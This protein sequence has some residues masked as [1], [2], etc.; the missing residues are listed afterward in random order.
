MKRNPFTKTSIHCFLLIV[1]FFVIGVSQTSAQ[2]KNVTGNVKDDT[3]E[4]LPGA[5]IL[6]VGTTLGTMTDFDGNFEVRV[7]EKGKAISIS[8]LGYITQEIPYTGQD[9]INVMLKSDRSQLEEVVVVGYGTQKAKDVT[10]AISKIKAKDIEKTT[11][12]TVEQALTG[13]VAGVNTISSDGSLGGGMRIRIRGGTSVN[14]N[15]E[16]LYVIDGLPVEVDYTLNQVPG[17]IDQPTASPLANLDPGSIVSIEVLKDA[18]AAAIYGSRGANGVVMITTK[19]GKAGKTQIVYDTN[20]SLSIVPKNRYVKMMNTTQYGEFLVNQDRYWLGVYRP[21][22]QFPAGSGVTAEER[23]EAYK[24]E[25]NTNWQD[26][27]YQMGIITNH[28]ISA[29]GGSEGNLFSVRGAYL[30]NEGTVKNSF[31]KRYNFTMNTQ[32][33]L[34]DKLKIKTS[35]APSY[36][37]KQGPTSGGSFSQRNMGSII[38]AM[39]RQPNRVV[40][41]VEI[42]DNEDVGV[43]VDPI[44]E[45]EKTKQLTTIFSFTGNTNLIYEIFKGFTA[46]FKI[47]T[48]YSSGLVKNYF[49]KE[50]GRGW[51]NGGLG[52]RYHYTNSNVNNQNMLNYTTSFDGGK[53]RITALAGFTQTYLSIDTERIESKDFAV[54]TLGFDGLQNGQNPSRPFTEKKEKV[55]KSFLARVNYNMF[56]KYNF[57]VSM[58]ADGSSVFVNNKW[59][60]FPAAAFAWNMNGEPFIKNVKDISNMRLRLSYGQTGNAG[61]PFYNSYSLM[62]DT[63]PVFGESSSAVAGLSTTNVGDPNLRWEFTDQFDLGYEL[64]LFHNRINIVAD[65]YYK[66]TQDLLLRQPIALSTGFESNLTNIG[67]VENRGLELSLKTVNFDGDFK[68]NTEFNFALN[69]NKVLSLGANTRVTFKDQFSQQFTGLLQTGESLGNWIGYETDGIFR[70]EDFEGDKVT[71]KPELRGL[72][73]NYASDENPLVGDIKYIDRN[74][75]GTIDNLDRTIIARTQPKHY[76]SV[77]NSFSYKGFDLGV[78]FTYKYG[79]DVIN[80]NK[81]RISNTVNSNWN[82]MVSSVDAWTPVNND[83]SQPRPD[84]KQDPNFNDRSI[85]DGSFIRLQSINIGYNLPKNICGTLGLSSLKLYSNVDNIHIWTKYTGYDPEVSVAT[86]QK[87]VTSA[88]LDYG[89]YP[90]TLNLSLGI[91]VG[92]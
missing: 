74:Q 23:L 62:S 36:V 66:R 14:A 71:L 16:P 77:Y 6:V 32:N 78:F 61:V 79:V 33:K 1:F 54:E 42:D 81:H 11:N 22:A 10:G 51:Q 65:I 35:L 27:F 48:N 21:Y 31:F 67:N 15:N 90:R 64:G 20:T 49:S 56:N 30:N 70:Y 38:K 80:G 9:V 45:A 13:R 29:S 40:G 46:N 19:T 55:L 2:S 5:S 92:F 72:Y 58:R 63:F 26:E 43:W 7:T 18:S 87:A 73:G 39:S 47:G 34:T 82:K 86:G 24:L 17:A 68:W 57:T 28:S 69:R 53:H 91:R 76:G 44:T 4:L 41:Q 89:A 83:G 25:P 52:T 12:V 50:F 88:N 8:S 59:G 60:Y 75:D 3:G 85:E 84:Y 37:I